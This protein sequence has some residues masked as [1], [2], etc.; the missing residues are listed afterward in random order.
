MT[1]SDGS[2]CHLHLLPITARNEP[3]LRAIHSA[4]QQ[5]ISASDSGRMI[6]LLASAAEDYPEVWEFWTEAGRENTRTIRKIAEGLQ[7]AQDEA[8]RLRHEAVIAGMKEG[9]VEP[10]FEP[11]SLP[12]E[13]ALAEAKQRHWQQWQDF[14]AGNMD[15]AKRLYFVT[16]QWPVSLAGIK[17]GRPIIQ[18]MIDR[19]RMNAEDVELIDGAEDS[20]FWMDAQAVEVARIINY[21]RR[22]V[23]S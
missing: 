9:D 15:L 7:A 16:D 4:T 6:D 1:K 5:H 12:M 10:T 13:E 18:R 3:E 2:K 14:L 23:G 22:S 21:F 11:I 19:K 20:D 17:A 8:E